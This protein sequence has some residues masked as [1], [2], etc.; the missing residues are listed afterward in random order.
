MS[1]A[2][3]AAK[4]GMSQANISRI[5]NGHQNYTLATCGHLAEAVGCIFVAS[6]RRRPQKK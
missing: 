2:E 4:V 5:E 1:Q 6:I 3:L